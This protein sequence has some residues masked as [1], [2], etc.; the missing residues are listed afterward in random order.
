MSGRL[1][2]LRDESGLS[3][4]EVLVTMIIVGFV[5]AGTFQA[6]R[7]TA[8]ADRYQ[9]DL[10]TVMDDSR[11]SLD[12]IRK[13]LRTTRLVLDSSDD[14]HL[15][16]WIDAD[17]DN[18]RSTDETINYAVTPLT[19]QPGKFVLSRYT[20][21]GGVASAQVIARTLVTTNVFTYVATAAQDEDGDGILDC[22]NG[23]DPNQACDRSREEL[24]RLDMEF[25]VAA[26]Q[27]PSSFASSTTIR[28]RNVGFVR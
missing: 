8:Q 15:V 23:T 12:R 10:R 9:A 7:T 28:L 22:P 18:V 26:S 2:D 1:T 21:A 17:N 11:N 5:A 27:G 6:V 16:F 14:D 3:L 4:V 19:G 24:I 25:D 20:D 13:E